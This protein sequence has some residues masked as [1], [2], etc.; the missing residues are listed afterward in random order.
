[1]SNS[2]RS[3]RFIEKNGGTKPLLK[4]CF[5]FYLM[6]VTGCSNPT[7]N[8][9]WS[10]AENQSSGY[11]Y[12]E[13][14]GSDHVV[15]NI[16]EHV[17]YE[18]SDA[19]NR[20]ATTASAPVV[21]AQTNAIPPSVT[22][23]GQAPMPR[24]PEHIGSYAQPA[25]A[26]NYSAPAAPAAPA[27][28]IAAVNAN[29][30]PELGSQSVMKS[31]AKA[32]DPVE[33]LQPVGTTEQD[34][35]RQL[36]SYQK[37]SK[38]WS[39]F[40]NLASSKLTSA[41][42][43]ATKD[44]FSARHATAEL[45]LSSGE[46]GSRS[47]SFDLLL[48]VFD[49]PENLVYTQVGI[50]RSNAHTEDYRNTVNLG[51]GYRRQVDTWLLG[52]NAFYDRD[53]TGKNDRLGIGA[54]AWAD[55]V[56]LSANGY[57]RISDWKQSPDLQDYLERPAN[58]WDVRAEAYLPSYP[59]LGGKLIYEQY[60]G[61]EVGLFSA[62]QRQ[63]DPSAL[64]LGLTYT[65]MPIL[66]FGV[67]Y[68]QGQNGLSESSM[69]MSLN[70][71]FGVPL[72]QQLSSDSLKSSRM[73]A[74]MRY[75]LVNRNNEIVLDYKK[76]EK[77]F[78][79]LPA[80][81]F[82]TPTSV[83]SF[84]VRLAGGQV[85]N[86]TWTGTA[87]S[88]AL[89]YNGSGTATITLPAINA[90]LNTYTLQAIGT[91]VY[92]QT[93]KSNVMNVTVTPF[94]ISLAR[95]KAMATADGSD[96][97][98]FTASLLEPNGTAR[99]NTDIIW[100]VSGAA[101]V[102]SKDAKTNNLG[103]ANLRLVSMS[104]STVSVSAREPQGASATAEADFLGDPTSAKI[105][106]LV[107]TPNSIAANGTSTS[108]LVAS[109]VDKNGSKLG[110]GIPV[111]WSATN[112]TLATAS[113]VT[114]A[115]S[116][117][118]VVLT[119]PTAIGSATV[120]ATAVAGSATAN[121]AFT[122]DVASARILSLVAAP[123]SIPADGTSTS[124]LTATIVDGNGNLV[125]AGVP[126]SWG[127][128][129]GTLSGASSS[130][131]ASSKAVITLKSSSNIGAATVT[132]TAAAGQAS[133]PVT[134]TST[135]KVVGVT[136]SPTSITAN[137]SSTSTL[138]ATVED[139]NGNSIPGVRVS[140]S[141]TKG[142]LSAAS[143]MT[144]GSSKAT[145]D[146]T[147]STIA[148][149]ATITATA[150]VGSGTVVV[151]F[152]ADPTTAQVIGVTASPASVVANGTATST[153]SATVKDANGN[154]V[155]NAPVSWSATV[156]TLAASTSTTGSA[157]IAT[158]TISSTTAGASIIT[159]SAVAG[160]ADGPLT[161]TPNAPVIN[162]FSVDSNA[163]YYSGEAYGS[164]SQSQQGVYQKSNGLTNIF[165][166]SVSNATRFEL[167]DV[168]PNRIVYSGTGTSYDITGRS[169]YYG[170]DPSN[171]SGSGT[172]RY[173]LR[174][175]NGATVT[176]STIQPSTTQLVCGGSCGGD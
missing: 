158:V 76:A 71:Q 112:G 38:D 122:A 49:T 42:S 162:G 111:T 108:T 13:P 23:P 29:A 45:K 27:Q 59:Q 87:S 97:V 121:V 115:D 84:A 56:K 70:Y 52:A 14:A 150:A 107:A 123:N 48:P 34:L 68:R 135:A 124:T 39:D 96:E 69:R 140:W 75:D 28:A 113:T 173:T 176:S 168:G 161:F 90:T 143:S 144:D 159:A 46:R 74:N 131:D 151:T 65:P 95:S 156:G 118:T 50:R 72:S 10:R 132:A 128:T 51:A 160:A 4:K 25:V 64:T 77:A 36:A 73:L 15:Y 169:S 98:E 7:S 174:A 55:F 101:T 18:L 129:D 116:N 91:D 89:P 24:S 146:L 3:V 147:S 163:V 83:V 57:F 19:G 66:G 2:Y 157:G 166:W 26:S 43:Q 60:Y 110:A 139:A 164:D 134:F 5:I 145:I 175:Y 165:R 172:R 148:G 88:F 170:A 78:L 117:A 22:A 30:L 62:T 86:V 79:T 104:S 167:V 125:G 82:G 63:K 1:M 130:T 142:T 114:D 31:E 67:D 81:V 21:R 119:S 44:W 149:T 154:L 102:V 94:L 155:E 12:G 103:K 35:Q 58:G 53:L 153:L 37:T 141:T 80:E 47:G 33:R 54:E 8:H 93:V 41:T 127:T 171:S 16:P 133:T 105:V 136:A 11:V 85:N 32:A 126:V 92:G 120:T 9:Y 17:V 61:D 152:V 109:V 137:G 40:Q 106:G 100:D 6:A 20:P 99:A 138:V